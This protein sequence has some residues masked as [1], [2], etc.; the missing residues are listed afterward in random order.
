MASLATEPELFQ[1]WKDKYEA[2]EK[3][4]RELIALTREQSEQIVKL[5]DIM[6]GREE[7]HARTQNTLQDFIHA[8][9][10]GQRLFNFPLDMDYADEVGDEL[11]QGE[12]WN[13]TGE[14]TM[15]QYAQAALSL[16]RENG[17]IENVLDVREIELEVMEIVKEH[18]REALNMDGVLNY[19][20]DEN[21]DNGRTQ[22]QRLGQPNAP[23]LT[24]TLSVEEQQEELENLDT[25]EMERASSIGKDCPIC[26]CAVHS[27]DERNG[28]MPCCGNVVHTDCI[29]VKEGTQCPFCRTTDIGSMALNSQEIEERFGTP[30]QE[31]TGNAQTTSQHESA[32][33]THN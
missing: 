26:L 13:P 33:N 25:T 20:D 24:R 3:K 9:G 5:M 29:N 4:N 2:A 14:R 19:S 11:Q 23:S 1:T 10:D 32:G 27:K 8:R 30:E 17:E 18:A 12:G 15:L 16:A 6:K 7:Q 31:S 21:E 22:A 28:A